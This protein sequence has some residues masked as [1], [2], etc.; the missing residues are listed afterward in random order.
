MPRVLF[1]IR[2][3]VLPVKYRRLGIRGY[4]RYEL[5]VR[6]KESVPLRETTLQEIS[7]FFGMRPSG[8]LLGFQP[9]GVSVMRGHNQHIECATGINL[10]EFLARFF[11]FTQSAGN[12]AR[13]PEQ[14]VARRIGA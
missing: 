12:V 13:V 9:Q 8:A 10:G 3:C 14:S 5:P 2:N 7:G 6:S 1:S 4:L 11:K